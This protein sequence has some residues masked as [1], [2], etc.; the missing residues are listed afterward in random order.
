MGNRYDLANSG[1]PGSTADGLPPLTQFPATSLTSQVSHFSKNVRAPF[2][3]VGSDWVHGR[4]PAV[5]SM[6]RTSNTRPHFLV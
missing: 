3:R 1:I 4:L 6:T 2:L 5:R